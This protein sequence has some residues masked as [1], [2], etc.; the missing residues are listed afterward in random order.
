MLPNSLNFGLAEASDFRSKINAHALGKHRFDRATTPESFRIHPFLCLDAAKRRKIKKNAK[1]QTTVDKNVIFFVFLYLTARTENCMTVTQ[2]FIMNRV[3]LAL[4]TAVSIATA[5]TFL[6]CEE[7]GKKAEAAPAAEEAS[8][9]VSCKAKLLES[10]TDE[11]GF[12]NKFEYDAHN[13]I[14]KKYNSNFTETITYGADGSVK[15]NDKPYRKNGNTIYKD[16]ETITV[17]EDGYVI[18]V[19][20]DYY[21]DTWQYQ[22]GN[23]ISIKGV[24][25]DNGNETLSSYS[26]DDK[27]SP[28]RN[29]KTPRWLLGD[30]NLSGD[31]NN[32][33]SSVSD[34]GLGDMFVNDF[35]YEYDSDGFPIEETVSFEGESQTRTFT[36]CGGTST[37]G[38][39]K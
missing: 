26:Y 33:L 38:A 11:S 19:E 21:N 35:S 22:G 25:K 29:D 3:K 36:Y 32:V 4:L 9:P 28:L 14:I 1:M 27:P 20:N 13:R 12:I 39:N 5:F 2:R 10:I 8:A 7:K 23:L 37:K 18:K 17:N 34:N 15:I 31:N 24:R 6:A 30:L 16:N